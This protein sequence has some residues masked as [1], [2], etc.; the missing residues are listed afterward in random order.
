MVTAIAGNQADIAIALQSAQGVAATASQHRLYLTGGGLAPQKET[1]DIAETTADRL[2]SS[3]FVTR[4]QAGGAPQFVVR[5]NAIGMFLYGAMGAKAV[6]GVADPRT[7]TFT[8]ASVLP[9]FTMWRRLGPLAAGG[10]YEKFI[11]CKVAQLA[12][13]SQAGGLLQA[14]ATIMGLDAQSKDAAEVTV[15]VEDAGAGAFIHADGEGALQLEGVPVASIEAFGLTINNNSTIQQGDSVSGYAVTEAL[16]G[17][18]ATTTLLVEDFALWNRFIYGAADPTDGDGPSRNILELGGTNGLDFKF[19]RPGAPERSL[20]FQAPR[21]EAIPQTLEPNV[22]GDPLKHQITMR[23]KK[24]ASGSGLT[25][26][27][28]NALTGY[29]A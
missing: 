7:H 3:A 25:V 17:I 29:A 16:L 23:V 4:V 26:K 11:D 15:A 6:A 20:Q 27:L 1:E 19:T 5:P 9:Y 13:A 24:P 18:E 14:T 21:V 22:N 28:L 10:L 8:L 2:R 12:F